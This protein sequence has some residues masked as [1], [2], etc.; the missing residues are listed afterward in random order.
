M[1]NCNGVMVGRM[2]PLDRVADGERALDAH[3]LAWPTRTGQHIV[4]PPI[5]LLRRLQRCGR[6]LR[7][8]R[9]G[10]RVATTSGPRV[11]HDLQQGPNLG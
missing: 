9:G 7:A 6:V 3:R 11:D 1:S 10:L 2:Q 8:Q 5:E 4:D